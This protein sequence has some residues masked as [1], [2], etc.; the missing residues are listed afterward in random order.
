M[1]DLNELNGDPNAAFEPDQPVPHQA[2]PATFEKPADSKVGE[3]GIYRP[4]Q[5]KVNYVETRTLSNPKV[6]GKPVV[7]SLLRESPRTFQSLLEERESFFA[8]LGTKSIPETEDEKLWQTALWDAMQ[9]TTMEETPLRATE[10]AES[11]WVQELTY[12]ESR[13]RSGRPKQKPTHARSS[14]PEIHSFLTKESGLGGTHDALLPHSGVWIRL[15]VPTLQEVINMQS[16]L[17]QKRVQL[18]K[19]TKGL[20]LSNAGA[21]MMNVINDLALNC[22]I[23]SNAKYRTPSDLEQQISSLDEPFLHSAL[24]SAMYSDG[25]NYSHP[26]IADVEKCSATIEAHLNML[27][28]QWYDQNSFT[29]A[30]LQHLMKRFNA[31]EDE[32]LDTYRQAFSRGGPRIVWFGRIGVQLEVPTIAERRTAGDAWIRSIVDMTQGAFNEA[33]HEANRSALIERLAR[34]ST[35]RQYAQWVTQI[36]HREDE[37]AE[38][39]FITDDRVAIDDYLNDI[40]SD[41]TYSEQFFAAVTKYIDDS[42]VGLVAIPSFNCTQ[43]NTPQASVFHER[44]PHL[45]PLDTVTTFFTLAARK[46]RT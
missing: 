35:A 4:V 7:L 40:L 13:V 20:A 15:R 37:Q 46:A 23:G 25:F 39:K 6:D 17:V 11:L 31:C 1:N 26:C 9:N 34:A 29:E 27:D 44:M 28:L 41:G 42:L 22:V 30:Q 10:R 19:E 3:D 16:S 43:C 5:P 12:G 45:I 2:A 8:L 18:G 24:A 32:A 38:I 33:P 14:R 21:V 36:H